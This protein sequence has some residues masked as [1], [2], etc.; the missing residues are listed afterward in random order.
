MKFYSLENC[1]KLRAL[2][3][4][5]ESGFYWKEEISWGAKYTGK[6]FLT[7]ASTYDE[8]ELKRN[9]EYKDHFLAAYTNLDFLDITETARENCRKRWGKEKTGFN[10]SECFS[11]GRGT[12]RFLVS[13]EKHRHLMLDSPDGEKY[14][15]E[16]L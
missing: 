13:W 5:S 7:P 2:G 3:C 6:W 9:P 12:A 15:M 16:G 4:V 11:N 10:L 14:V 1:K 8:T